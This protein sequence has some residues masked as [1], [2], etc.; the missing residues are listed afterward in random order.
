MGREFVSTMAT[1]EILKEN[2]PRRP[3]YGVQTLFVQVPL[4]DLVRHATGSLRQSATLSLKRVFPF[5]CWI[6]SLV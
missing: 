5:L 4:S 3:K 1:T 6:S 2:H